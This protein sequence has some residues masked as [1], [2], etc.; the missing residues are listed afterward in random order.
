M[1]SSNTPWLL[2]IATLPTESATARMRIWRALKTLGGAAL[3]D[4]AYLLPN[5]PALSQ[6]AGKLCDETRQE[7]GSAWVLPITPGTADEDGAFTALFDRQAEYDAFLDSLNE[8]RLSLEA[9]ELPKASRLQRKLR[10]DYEAIR[11]ID[12]F[13][14]EHSA[15]AEAAWM[16][17]VQR[18]AELQD[19]GEP[20]QRRAPIPSLDLREYQ[21]RRWATR[22][23]IGVDRVCS[24]WLI[25]RFIDPEATFVWLDSPRACPKNA[26]GFDFDDAP[27]THIGERVT[28]EVLVASFGL[29]RDP[30]LQRLG[31][32]VRSLDTGAG[33]APEAAGFDAM[34]AGLRQRAAGD[35]DLLKQASP[36]LDALYASFSSSEH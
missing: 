11:A 24:A 1:P 26:L 21:S 9:L 2:L 15:R 30:A 31:L 28:F 36:L 19:A 10:K 7:G 22:R 27:F 29:D 32:L 8:A 35:D 3:R 25:A 18:L 14:N 34:L 5:Q 12:Y 17:F 33:Y 13:P 16:G 4:G 20:R 23:R 6:A